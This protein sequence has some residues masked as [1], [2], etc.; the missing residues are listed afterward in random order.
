MDKG[1]T[2]VVPTYNNEATLAGCLTALKEQVGPGDEILVVDDASG[3]DSAG[4]A[5]R[6]GAAVIRRA[7]NA[8]AAAARNEGAREARRG[9]LFFVDADVVLQEGALAALREAFD[10]GYDAVVGH[11]E[12]ETPAPGFFSRFQNY[13]TYFNHDKQEGEIHWFWTAMGAVRRDVFEGLGGFSEH[14]RGAS[15]EDME[16][17]YRLSRAGYRILLHKGVRGVH[18]HRHTLCSIIKNDLKKSAAWCDVYLRLNRKGDYRHGFTGRANRISLLMA[19]VLPAATAAAF[20]WPWAAPLA[21]VAGAS[22]IAA[23]I[24]FA[25]FVRGRAGW[26][27]ALRAFLFYYFTYFLVGIGVTR[28]VLSFVLGR[29]AQ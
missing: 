6:Y 19:W 20:F 27:F 22:F 12:P 17:G 24:S 26:A 7:R 10:R 5:A 15:A 3:D 11:Y 2:I 25:R 8:G 21:V 16:L 23:N 29:K 28:G 4:V 14:F 1:I 18:C 13:Y 9:Y